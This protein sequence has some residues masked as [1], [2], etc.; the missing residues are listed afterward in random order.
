VRTTPPPPWRKPDPLPEAALS[1][2]TIVRWYR[3]EDAEALHRAVDGSREA[4]LPWLPW[5]AREHASPEESLACIDRFTRG[6]NFVD[7]TDFVL[8]IFER[9]TGELLGG[10][11]FHRVV[12]EVA[13]AETGYWIRA[14]RRGEGLCT[15]ATAAHLTAGFSAWGFRRIKI[16]CAGGNRASQRIPE[17]L[18]LR[19]EGRERE[20]RW[21]D[22]AGWQDHLTFAVLA[23]EWDARAGRVR[24]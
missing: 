11:G 14:D 20:A 23:S 9:G 2:R 15:E 22:G 6:R 3:R 10:T 5:A 4:L 21:V 18:G 1:R 24:R 17:K 13:E 12:A 16:C 8:G 19:L 7:A